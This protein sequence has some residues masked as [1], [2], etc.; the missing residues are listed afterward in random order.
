MG[1]HADHPSINR[2]ALEEIWDQIRKLLAEERTRHQ[3]YFRETERLHDCLLCQ[4]DGRTHEQSYGNGHRNGFVNPAY[5][6]SNESGEGVCTRSGRTPIAFPHIVG[7]YKVSSV[8][9]SVAQGHVASLAANPG[10]EGLKEAIRELALRMI[11]TS[12]E[13]PQRWADVRETL[14]NHVVRNT[15][16][17]LQTVERIW[18]FAEAHGVNER[19]DLV[20]MLHFF[21]AQGSLLYLPQLSDLEEIVVL[22]QEWLARIF[23]SVVSS[24]TSPVNEFGLVDRNRLK[25]S[26]TGVESQTR[27]KVLILL[28]YFGMCFPIDDTQLEMFPSK[29]PHGDP[30]HFAWPPIPH[31]GQRQVT[32]SMTFLSS[33]PPPFFNNLMTTVY[34]HRASPDAVSSSGQMEEMTGAP[35][36][37]MYFSNLFLETLRPDSVGC[38]N[39][40]F[41]RTGSADGD[42]E[43]LNLVHQVYIIPV[44]P[45]IHS[46]IHSSI[47][48]SVH[49]S[50]H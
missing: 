22:D 37:P 3:D 48:S 49:S 38:R 40:G 46:S 8:R 19:T 41:R 35:V 32:H 12:P 36:R 13:I 31:Q 28:R 25:D 16:S 15:D 4:S 2:P 1:T 20:N 11:R 50:I 44:F 24:K 18:R 29:L 43:E 30:D 5:E 23:A 42:V 21:R 26:W 9:G 7:Y 45:F 39:C 10:V 17:C 27:E 47:Y 34:S 33:I 6:A 14:R